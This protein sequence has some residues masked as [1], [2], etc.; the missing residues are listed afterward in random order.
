MNCDQM[1][2]HPWMQMEL[3]DENKVEF[4][5][6]QEYIKTRKDKVQQKGDEEEI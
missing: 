4:Q 2:A 5:N 3:D 6:L 1:L